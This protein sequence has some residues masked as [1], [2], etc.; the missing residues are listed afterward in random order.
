MPHA[1]HGEHCTHEH[2]EKDPHVWLSPDNLIQLADRFRQCFE[3]LDPE[4]AAVYQKNY[5]RYVQQLK[6][7]DAEISRQ[8]APFSGSRIYVFHPSYGYFCDVYNL[9]QVPVELEGKSPS[10]RQLVALIE[11]AKADGVQ[12]LFVQ[13]QFPV[14]SAQAIAKA[15]NG[16][17]IPLDPLAEDSIANLRLMSESIAQ[18][19]KQ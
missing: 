8:L 11:Q 10:P 13:K 19:L 7:L 18:A 4:Q 12:V 5:D 14:D 2:G 17:V 3:Q 1:H 6:Q 16:R 9:Q 15:I